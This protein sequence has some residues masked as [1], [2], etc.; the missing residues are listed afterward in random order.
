MALIPTALRCAALALAL[1]LLAATPAAAEPGLADLVE[2]LLPGVVTISVIKPPAERVAAAHSGIPPEI[3]HRFF[4]Q[5]PDGAPDAPPEPTR[6]LGSG[7]VIDG[8]GLIVTN[9][10]VIEGGETITVTLADRTELAAHLVGSDPA[11]DLALLKIEP[12]HPLASLA[13]GD[14]D[15]ARIGE[16]V[17]AIGNPFG[18][19][20]TV[21]AG[22]L[23][24]RARDIGSGPYDDFLQTDA[25]INRGNSGGPLINLAGEVI[26]INTAIFS[27]P[28]QGG[29][30]VGIA[31]AIPS[32][33]ARPLVEQL[34][35]SGKVRRGAIGVGI[36]DVTE[37]IAE[38]LGLAS[39]H[40]ALVTRAEGPAARAHIQPGDIILAFD[41]K[42]VSDAARLPRLV[43]ATPIAS[44]VPVD[45]WR[46]GGLLTVAVT[47]AEL[48]AEQ[49]ASKAEAPQE[50]IGLPE[51]GLS[52]AM[53]TPELR[54]QFG[55]EDDAEGVVVT[56]VED[57]SDAAEQGVR[58]GDVI[59]AVAMEEVTSLAEVTA[60]IDKARAAGENTVLLLVEEDGEMSFVDLMLSSR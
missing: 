50:E 1:S 45:L 32:A 10:H 21:T 48:A 17:I 6:S 55:L 34:T 39:A 4:P 37:E 26:G 29:G 42:P 8:Q 30:S 9:N 38:S 54:D 57:D 47:I 35:H 51:L 49:A 23:S 40:G 25:P 13:W 31:F 24:A 28:G 44:S 3:L 60:Q 2:K 53:I 46:R 11:S 5:M 41:G 58:P 33:Q 12:K 19:G 52:L 18:L 22:I 43:A 14:S 16:T 56:E 20:G 15:K 27:P 7:F 36:E 59:R